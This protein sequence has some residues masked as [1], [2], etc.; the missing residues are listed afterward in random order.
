MYVNAALFKRVI[1]QAV[2]II[3]ETREDRH[4][5]RN[6][7]NNAFNVPPYLFQVYKEQQQQKTSHMDNNIK[8][9]I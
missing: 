9:V 7:T 1:M 8:R 4:I 2:F 3:Q 6:Y 5:F